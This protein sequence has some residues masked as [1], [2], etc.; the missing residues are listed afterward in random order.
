[1]GRSAALVLAC[2][3]AAGC[4]GHADVA[5]SPLP[6]PAAGRSRWAALEAVDLATGQVLSITRYTYDASG[7]RSGES[8]WVT[9]GGVP[10]GRPDRVQTW[11]YD[12]AHRMR[13]HTD[14][15]ATSERRVDATYGSD[16]LLASVTRTVGT[17]PEV[18][19]LVRWS[20]LRMVGTETPGSTIPSEQAFYGADGRIARIERRARGVEVPDVDTYAWR[21]DGQIAS[22]RFVDIGHGVELR[23]DYDAA[24]RMVGS[25]ATDDGVVDAA[26]RYAYD[27]RGRVRLVELDTERWYGDEAPFV[28]R[29]AYR[30]RWQDGPCQPTY[31]PA[32]PPSL[33]RDR[34][35]LASADGT[36]LGCGP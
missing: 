1:M 34:T 25:T 33:D 19:T 22:A 12:E 11:T 9:A 28:A 32:I 15:D 27:D 2:T 21:P 3:L 17:G 8:T 16:G 20:G 18:T 4:G 7:L 5:D 26:R 29:F 6:L 35:L 13:V 31:E 30:I 23:Y 14:V 36:S 10:T 24:G